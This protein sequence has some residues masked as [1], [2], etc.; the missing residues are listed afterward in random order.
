MTDERRDCIARESVCVCICVFSGVS[1]GCVDIVDMSNVIIMAKLI[2]VV[3]DCKPIK[4]VR[5]V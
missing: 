5:E 1:H 4:V 2:Y 3:L